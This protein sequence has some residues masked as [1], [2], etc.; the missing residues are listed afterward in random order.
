MIDGDEGAYFR[1]QFVDWQDNSW[2]SGD[3][4]EEK[5]EKKKEKQR[6]RKTIHKEGL[7]ETEL[8]ILQELHKEGYLDKRHGSEWKRRYFIL[9]SGVLYRYTE[10]L[11]L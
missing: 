2:D 10:V 1:E 4:S 8:H 5:K 7:S 3:K 11:Y 6:E 9:E